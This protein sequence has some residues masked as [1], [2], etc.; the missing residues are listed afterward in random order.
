MSTSV[1]ETTYRA[2]E[3]S[4][5]G[6][7]TTPALV[8]ANLTTIR[9]SDFYNLDA[10]A[11]IQRQS[12]EKT[13]AP[14]LNVSESV[15]RVFSAQMVGWILA[16]SIMRDGQYFD[17][18]SASVVTTLE[19]KLLPQKTKVTAI[20][21]TNIV[22][23]TLL[24]HAKFAIPD[25]L[26]TVALYPVDIFVTERAKNGDSVNAFLG[27]TSVVGETTSIS[28]EV[29]SLGRKKKKKATT[30]NSRLMISL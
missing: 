2:L 5:V 26:N 23:V 13:V 25:D 14:S 11:F 15:A 28:S 18:V 9:G 19:S 12:A 17:S 6:F 29:D 1:I 8:A 30:S 4:S 16:P 3:C 24:P 21:T 22:G 27:K 20:I 7:S 10:L